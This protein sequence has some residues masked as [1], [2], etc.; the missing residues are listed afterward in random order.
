MDNN[1][2]LDESTMNNIKK[3][4]DNGNLSEAMSQISPEMIQNLSNMLNSQNSSKEVSNNFNNANNNS[5]SDSNST[6]QGINFNNISPEMIMK[7]SSVMN[8]MNNK[9]DSRANLLYSLKPYL[10]DSRK[11]K[12]DQYVNL[13]NISKIADIL[14]DEK[15][16]N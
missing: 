15:K 14:K 6:N 5:K 1:F 3:M 13:L 4:V 10:R 7:L 8:E 9:N 16:E 2:N 12:L 11:E